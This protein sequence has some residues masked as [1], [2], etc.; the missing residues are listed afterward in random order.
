MVVAGDMV[1]DLDTVGRQG[2]LDMVFDP[3]MAYPD[4]A[5]LGMVYLDMEL[6]LE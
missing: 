1:F 5:Y 6:V 2:M 3:G 4:T